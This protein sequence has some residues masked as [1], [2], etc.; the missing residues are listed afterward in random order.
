MEVLLRR[1]G[2][3]APGE[4]RAALDR[5]TVELFGLRVERR[6]NGAPYLACGVGLS[7]SH[8]GEWLALA[9]DRSGAACG[10]DI[11]LTGRN[12]DRV[13]PRFVRSEELE[14]VPYTSNPTLWIWCAKEALYK[15]AGR[16]GLDWLRD[17]RITAPDQGEVCGQS[18]SIGWREEQGLLVVWT[19][20]PTS[21]NKIATFR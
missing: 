16:E 13:S 11:E 4:R 19:E 15:V 1:I 12:A 5:W 8:T 10:V 6:A 20:S 17:I 9:V 3:L 14:Y 2:V 7:V 21:R 18:Y